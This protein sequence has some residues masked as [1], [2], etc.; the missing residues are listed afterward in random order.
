MSIHLKEHGLTVNILVIN[1][2][3]KERT[4]EFTPSDVIAYTPPTQ[5]KP[6]WEFVLKDS[7]TILATGNVTLILWKVAE[8][9]GRQG[10]WIVE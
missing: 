2:V 5:D 6:Y 8:D 4:S 1:D 9:K 7:R 10:K 3:Y